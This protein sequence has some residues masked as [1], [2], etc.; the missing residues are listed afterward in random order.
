[1]YVLD[2]PLLRYLFICFILETIVVIWL[3]HSLICCNNLDDYCMLKT[4]Y[5]IIY[6]RLLNVLVY[7]AYGDCVKNPDLQV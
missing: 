7:V 2:E 5:L 4:I 3:R 1:M 6:V